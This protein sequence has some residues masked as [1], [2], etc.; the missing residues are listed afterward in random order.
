[1]TTGD[2]LTAETLLADF[3]VVSD[4]ERATMGK[5]LKVPAAAALDPDARAAFIEA[6]D[7]LNGK[8][9]DVFASIP[10]LEYE[11]TT[12]AGN[13][14]RY[15][16]ESKVAELTAS[17]EAYA[18][19]E[20]KPDVTSMMEVLH[21]AQG[22]YGSTTAASDRYHPEM[23]AWAKKISGKPDKAVAQAHA[24]AY[25]FYT[26]GGGTNYRGRLWT[27]HDACK[28]KA[29]DCIRASQ[30][31]A[32]AYANA[33]YGGIHP[34]RICRG[35]FQ[36][37]AVGLSG[38]TFV[39]LDA[40]SKDVCLDPL[41]KRTFLQPFEKMHARDRTVVSVAKGYRSL[42]SFVSGQLRFPQGPVRA[43]QL[44]VPYYH[45]KREGFSEGH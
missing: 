39:C 26:Q 1:L 12:L 8:A 11:R 3:C 13:L 17:L 29:C 5:P 6:H 40:G 16:A 45:L 22:A 34:I 7:V 19:H 20:K 14:A 10:T 31:M 33:G 27:I 44:R 41:L 38:H 18:K 42:E 30:M 9:Q 2:V 23:S 25:G 37:K 28:A 24:L 15:A 36:Q 32:S 21:I 43:V 35:N 4:A